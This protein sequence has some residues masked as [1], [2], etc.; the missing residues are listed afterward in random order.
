M[1]LFSWSELEVTMIGRERVY[2]V[3]RK[4]LVGGFE[5]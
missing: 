1:T 3:S 2:P 5:Y 4:R